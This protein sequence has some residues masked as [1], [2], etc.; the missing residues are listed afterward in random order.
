[1]IKI[2]YEFINVSHSC[3]SIYSFIYLLDYSEYIPT[4]VI[5]MFKFTS[6]NNMN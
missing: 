5:N 3:I 1:M 6:N 2:S 4:L